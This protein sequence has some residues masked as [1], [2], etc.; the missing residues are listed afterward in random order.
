MIFFCLF[1]AF[2][3]FLAIT[4]IW[5]PLIGK[6]FSREKIL[7]LVIIFLLPILTLLLYYELG[8][9][10]SWQ[11][12][13]HRSMKPPFDLAAFESFDGL[14][15]GLEKLVVERPK[16]DQAWYYLGQAYLGQERYLEASQAFAIAYQLA[17][18]N[19]DIIAE[20]AQSLVLLQ[21]GKLSEHSGALLS[22]VLALDP[23][24]EAALTILG[25]DAFQRGDYALAITYWRQLQTRY[26]KDSQ[27][28]RL[29]EEV[30]QKAEN[31]KPQNE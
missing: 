31:N 9:Y 11:M 23:Q 15:E 29:L 20:Y 30:I 19:V 5:V 27:T 25:S 1:I 6:R 26:P 10:K 16:D 4:F 8:S 17:P 7:F 18:T 13:K 24:H 12:Y 22:E 28:W 3:L 21:N 14:V 2:F